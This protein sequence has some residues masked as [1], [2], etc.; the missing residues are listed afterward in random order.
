M[1]TKLLPTRSFF[2]APLFLV[3]VISSFVFLVSCN[4]SDKKSD[5]AS[6]TA[7]PEDDRFTQ[8]TLTEGMDEPMEMAFLPDGRVLIAERK[9]GLLSVDTKTKATKLIATIPVN[10]KYTSKEGVVSEAEEGLVGI[11]A[12]PKF[13]DNHWIYLY[14][15]DPVEKKHVL[16]RWELHGDSLYAAS[17]KIVLE[18]NT[19]RE[20]CCHTGGGMVFDQQGNLFIT[21]GNNT[22]NP[23]AGIASMDERPGR[24][25][26]DDQR[27]SGNT[28]DL[29]GKIL[30][31]HPEDDGSYT[32]PEGNL[33]PKGTAKTR[34]EI[35]VM[36]D[37]NPWRISIDSKTG[38]IYWGEVGPDASK[39]SI[40]GPRG[41]DEFNQAKKAGFFGWPYFIGDNKAYTHYSYTDSSYHEK[42]DVNHPV[43]NSPNNTGLKDLP[44]PQKAFIWYP[45]G[46][47]DTFPLVGSSG[48]SATGGPVF[49]HADF[50][51]AKRPFPDYFEGKWLITDFMRGWLMSVSLDENQNYKSMEQI[52]PNENFSS[53]IDMKF[54]PEGDLYILEYGSAWFRGNANSKLLRIEYNAGNR[55]PVVEASAEKTAAAV[56]FIVHLSSKGTKDYDP[57]DKDA[58]K[59]QWEIKSG[60]NVIKT[61][62]EPD[63]TITLDQ[64]GDYQATL[65]VTDTKG[66]KNSK[67]ISLQAGNERPQVSIDIGKGNKTFFFANE[68][69]DYS[70]QV[71]DKEDGSLADGKIKPDMVAVNFD[72][73][74]AGFDP[75]DIAAHHVA[76]DDRAGFSAGLYL[77][78]MNDCKT[79]HMPDKKSVGPSYT[80]VAQKY[81]ND[82]S[83][84]NRLAAK[85]ISGGVGVWGEHAMAAHPQL[86]PPEAEKMVKYI[87]S[88]GQKQA[89]TKPLPLKGTFTPKIPADEKGQGGY[90]LRAAYTDKGNGTASPLSAEKII[91]LRSPSL[92]P[93]LANEKKSTQLLT[94]PMRAFH[95]LGNNSYIGYDNIDLTGI[96]QIDFLVQVTPTSGAVG[97]V[98][99]VHLDSPDGQL[100][101]KTDMLVP[102]A[103]DFARIMETLGG[104]KKDNGKAKSKPAANPGAK[105]EEPKKRPP[106]DFDM[107]AKL[108]SV[109]ALAPITPTAGE[110]KVYIVGKNDKAAEK[111]ILLQMVE[112]NFQNK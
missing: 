61:S 32:I 22:A 48:R 101:G 100:I 88:V 85:V 21:V 108:M 59:Y 45:Y 38:Y 24:E 34:P 95:M 28:N 70:I 36:G 29:R 43:N 46:T 20:V 39:D 9:G 40:W 31:I 26:W 103:I 58:L 106:I 65:T 111:A 49:R 62:T 33:F 107:F 98:I 17:K 93:D 10:T 27:G 72:Y 6:S 30:R 81:K 55:K 4:Q 74:P 76:S 69:L 12:H 3:L 104:G 64:P 13:A 71:S 66:E 37:R 78:N 7:K 109:H 41:Y 57:Y 50:V 97:G 19:Q 53:A 63:P 2:Y 96:K 44:P 84:L 16:A 25:S 92:D 90:L 80:D 87:L 86:T 89:A 23:P 14:Y 77:I 42:F 68:P 35:Y 112:I 52:L 47:S 91:A 67:T 8:V 11:V 56:P 94:T 110:H 51:N 105:K 60:A 54:G 82:A 79:C 102:K 73:V 5:E 18:V 15:A 75:I 83:A 99:E 1:I